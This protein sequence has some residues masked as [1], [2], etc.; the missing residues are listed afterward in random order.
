VVLPSLVRVKMNRTG[1]TYRGEL[2]GLLGGG[3]MTSKDATILHALP[4]GALLV[5]ARGRV[6]ATNP[7]AEQLLGF[8]PTGRTTESLCPI[9]PDGHGFAPAHF[10]DE[11][12]AGVTLNVQHGALADERLMLLRPVGDPSGSLG[13]IR[14]LEAVLGAVPV[15]VAAVSKD[16]QVLY[17]NRAMEG[18]LGKPRHVL[19]ADLE[20][21]LGAFSGQ[22]GLWVRSAVTRA[23]DGEA[24][25][26]DVQVQT[27]VGLRQFELVA[28]PLGHPGG[29]VL[30]ARDVSRERE[31]LSE[32][33]GA[34][35]R[36]VEQL[37]RLAG[38]MAHDLN[39][40]LTVLA[41]AV[42]EFSSY[43]DLDPELAQ[44]VG[45][46]LRDC[47]S[48]TRDLLYLG[49]GARSDEL[50]PISVAPILARVAESLREVAPEGVTI[51]VV[52]DIQGA[53]VIGERE[54]LARILHHLG[55]NALRA[56]GLTGTVRLRGSMDAHTVQLE[57]EDDGIGIPR[58]LLGQVFQPMVS[59][60]R[61]GRAAGLGLTLVQRLVTNF[62]GD[63][64]VRSQVGRGSRFTI[65]FPRTVPP[66]RRLPVLPEALPR[67]VLLVDDDPSVRRSLARLLRIRGIEVH[68]AADGL[69]ALRAADSVQNL[70]LVL[71]DLVM[72]S[73][74]G[75]KVLALL[76]A[77][78]PSLPVLMM[79]G[80]AREDRI[81]RCLQAGALGFIT[82][83]FRLKELRQALAL[84]RKRLEAQ[85][86]NG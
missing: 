20:T 27:P 61:S 8:D 38:S 1:H 49:Q 43:E 65:V 10:L 6:I 78:H 63:I 76:A 75:D 58:E 2:P 9:L 4:D 51:D 11:Q 67:K 39:N 19:S 33:Q 81:E 64:A 56:V 41:T 13:A 72:P 83:P 21:L 62:G 44:M 55:V 84:G 30:V 18:T 3:L 40:G 68:E 24:V 47:R 16:R 74:P 32:V 25:M 46:A 7:K 36:E 53:H 69:D 29:C 59:L 48:L 85:G 14:R 79:S 15:L 12:G 66:E 52:D 77:T 73:F 31:L 34:A 5:D 86:Q 45:E 60:E 71:L 57:V 35:R 17:V 22:D 26:G 42:D 50:G 23:L 37:S 70:D 54:G 80:Y 28:E 82:K